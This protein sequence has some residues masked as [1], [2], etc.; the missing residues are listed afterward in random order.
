V[1]ILVHFEQRDC[2]FVHCLADDERTAISPML[3]ISEQETLIHALR[4]IGA[5][6]AEI[7]EVHDAIRRWSRGSVVV[8]LAPGRKNL[9]RIRHPW[10][11]DLK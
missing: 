7:L 11:A 9:L 5:G 2:W 3:R 8:T 10:S 1:R 4:Y 6:D